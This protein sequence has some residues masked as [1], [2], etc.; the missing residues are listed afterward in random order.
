[1]IFDTKYKYANKKLV[2]T[3]FNILNNNNNLLTS[4]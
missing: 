3:K 2:F 1:M 4:C